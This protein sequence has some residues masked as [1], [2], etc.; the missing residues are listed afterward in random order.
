MKECAIV[1]YGVFKHGT[2]SKK[3]KKKKKKKSKKLFK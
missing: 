3:K 2:Q 1:W